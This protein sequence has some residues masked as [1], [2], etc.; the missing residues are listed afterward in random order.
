MPAAMKTAPKRGR[1]VTTGT[2][3]PMTAP[4]RAEPIAPRP[5]AGA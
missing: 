3:P 5:E 2:T 1:P 4:P